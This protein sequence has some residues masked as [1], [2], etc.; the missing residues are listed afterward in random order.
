MGI[1]KWAYF[2]PNFGISINR[3]G[4]RMGTVSCRNGHQPPDYFS[5]TG[6]IP[7][8][9]TN[10]TELLKEIGDFSHLAKGKKIAR[11]GRLAV[12]G[13]KKITTD[14]LPATEA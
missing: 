3:K 1:S 13:R 6:P 4:L 2:F 9:T 10:I 5:Q 14:R 7:Y 11:E 8:Y 12:K